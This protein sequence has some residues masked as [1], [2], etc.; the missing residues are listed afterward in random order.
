MKLTLFRSPISGFRSFSCN[1]AALFLAL[2]FVCGASATE[3]IYVN[4]SVLNYAIPGT[5]PPT[6][7]AFNFV[8]NNQFNVT[9]E[10][11]SASA[12]FYE[13]MNV[14]NYTN[15]SSGVDSGLMTANSPFVT[16][17]FFGGIIGFNLNP[18]GVGLQYD[19]QT[20]NTIPHQM[21]GTFFNSGTIRC[22]SVLDGNNLLDGFFDQANAG[23]CLVW[24]SNVISS[25]TID[26][27]ENG[28]INLS[29]NNV[30]LTRGVVTLEQGLTTSNN[31]QAGIISEGEGINTNGWSPDA[32]LTA[33]NAIAS[34]PDNLTLSFPASYFQTIQTGPT[35][36]VVRAVFVVN[37]NTN[38]GLSV[39][40]APPNF[41]NEG[42]LL[43]WSGT[44]LDPVTGLTDTNYLYL[45]HYY[46][47]STNFLPILST[48]IIPQQADEGFYANFLWQQSTPYPG[49][50]APTAAGFQNIFGTSLFITNIYEYFNAS[51]S[52]TS[53]A[54]NASPS[55]PSGALTN[56]FGRIQITANI[57]FKMPLAQIS[58]ANYMSLTA[59]N[60]FD[61]SPGALVYSP[62][63]DLN[64]GVT[65]GYAHPLTIS[66]LLASSIPE[67]GGTLDEWSTRWLAED[68]NSN[69]IDY[70]VM[71]VYADLTPTVTPQVQNLTLTA[72]N[73]V[74]S[75]VLNV[76]GSTFAN[77]QSLTLT[78]NIY[79]AGATSPDG[80]LNFVNSAPL[81]WNWNASFPNLLW[82]TNSGALRM[83]NYSEFASSG[84]ITNI[85]GGSPGTQASATLAETALSNNVAG[86]TVTIV[87]TKYVFVSKLTNSIPFQV[88]VGT[89]IFGSMS[90]LIA[91]INGG[92][93]PGTN[94]STNTPASS[95][96]VAGP[97]ALGGG[98]GSFVVSANPNNTYYVGTGGNGLSVSSTITNLVWS[99]SIL[100]GG[101]NP[102]PAITNLTAVSVPYGAVINNSY[103]AGQG[104]TVL[105]TNFVNGGFISNGVGSFLLTADTA[106]L[107]N[108]MIVAGGDIS[109]AGNTL[110]ASNVMLQAG[111]SLTLQMTNLIWDGGVSNGNVWAVGAT[112]GTGGPGLNLLL[113]PNNNAPQMNSLL[114]TTISM[115]AP[116]P[117]KQVS[118]IWAGLD[119]GENPAGY[120]NNVAVGQLVLTSL[121]PNSGFFFSG[122][123]GSTVNNAI[124]VD[125]LVLSNYTSLAFSE[126]T[127]V[128]TNVLTATNF[129]IYYADAVSSSTVNGGALEDVSTIINGF[130]SGHLQ[131]VPQYV[132]YFSS[133]NVPYVNGTIN[134]LNVGL[135][136]DP[137]LDSNGSGIPNDES[138]D[139]VFVSSQIDF[140]QVLVSNSLERLTWISVPGATNYVQY[141]T[142]WFN[143]NVYT[144]FDSPLSS[145][146]WPITNMIYAPIPL[147]RAA[148]NCWFRVRIDQDNSVLYGQ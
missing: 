48:G 5:P 138:S 13:P 35:N 28:F 39:F 142:N 59:T 74:I 53:E 20:T 136:N 97:L 131:W 7:D 37:A 106:T 61:G 51:L 134:R 104:M 40:I 101:V 89:N 78:T 24:A 77:A 94:Y 137:Y 32:D 71:L 121:S 99:S 27:S 46:F 140:Q 72:S 55:N 29:G 64:L 45:F 88:K 126:G 75:D 66:N 31:V 16:N 73:V 4:N 30:D 122:P 21:A 109:L 10:N 76:F 148:S 103:I 128:L 87:G 22:D 14:V 47:N 70:R 62:F 44:Y 95:V 50:P 9:F 123:P 84:A 130:N 43:Q 1:L 107:T 60:Q 49:L 100:S 141:T 17:S 132:G 144:D 81:T 143:W 12:Q 117:N 3:P 145:A 110:L 147:N 98:N 133:T 91:A 79:G 23:Q 114:G 125:R 56:M 82:F 18:A 8:N 116:P 92:P 2:R 86:G 113:L 57:D 38:V 33:T 102:V 120:T 119:Y 6:I 19:T 54:T 139:P 67:W 85:T 63:S 83:P 115:T 112:N 26:A 15:S 68:I 135:V 11:E 108:G 69:F 36:F 129:T 90:N 111:R 127:T 80:E 65:N 105:A 96:A 42:A 93:G 41:A 25:G 34:P 146:N 118:S 52:G 58:G 124:Y